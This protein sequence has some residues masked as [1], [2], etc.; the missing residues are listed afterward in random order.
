MHP[1]CRQ[2][3]TPESGPTR[4]VCRAKR[5]QR[6]RRPLPARSSQ[7]LPS[8]NWLAAF[9]YISA[10]SSYLLPPPKRLKL[11]RRLLA[12]AT[13]SWPFATK[14]MLPPIS[15]TRSG[16]AQI[17]AESPRGA[18]RSKSGQRFLNCADRAGNA[19]VE[20]AEMRWSE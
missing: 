7:A 13:R 12:L 10:A 3:A 2:R 20:G 1:C 4:K 18:E 14:S 8:L 11:L 5:R 9:S 6:R 17:N 15:C 19:M 16:G